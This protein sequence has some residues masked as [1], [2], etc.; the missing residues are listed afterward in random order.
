MNGIPGVVLKRVNENTKQV[1]ER[2]KAKVAEINKSLPAGVQ[3]VDYY[4][5]AELVDNSIHTVVESLLEGEALV[6]LISV[7]VR[8]YLYACPPG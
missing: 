8:S 7:G 2:I 3:I 6:L 1:I 5:Q 4:D